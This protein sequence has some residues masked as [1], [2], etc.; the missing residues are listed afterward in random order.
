MKTLFT[1]TILFFG[2]TGFSQHEE[3]IE[4]VKTRE[5]K[6]K[7]SHSNRSYHYQT[8][9]IDRTN[10]YQVKLANGSLEIIKTN[11]L[12]LPIPY[13]YEKIVFNSGGIPAK[14]SGIFTE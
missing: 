12:W 13:C 8:A 5:I 7:T 3:K 1:I 14:Y 6:L 2:L 4:S 10:S 11:S 9:W